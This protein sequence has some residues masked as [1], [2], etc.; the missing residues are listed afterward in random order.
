MGDWTLQAVSTL[1][2]WLDSDSPV[3]AEV[4]RAAAAGEG[5]VDR[6]AVYGL[7]EYPPGR[8]LRGFARPVQRLTRRLQQERKLSVE[9]PPMLLPVYEK[10]VQAIAF[11]VPQAVVD[12]LQGAVL[13]RAADDG[14]AALA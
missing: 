3:Q 4:I 12:V 11:Q 5:T 13:N 8:M 10:G 6:E 9:A 2:A 7:G 1:L 14:K